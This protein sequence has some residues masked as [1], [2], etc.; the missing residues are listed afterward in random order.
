MS[1]CLLQ[2]EHY[3]QWMQAAQI[4]DHNEK[5]YALQVCAK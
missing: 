2:S 1:D 4:E 5:L 3:D